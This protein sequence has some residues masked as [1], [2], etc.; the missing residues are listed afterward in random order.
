M[1]IRKRGE[2]SGYSNGTG[3]WTGKRTVSLPHYNLGK[4][5]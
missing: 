2:Q 5:N 1:P 3:L 4:G